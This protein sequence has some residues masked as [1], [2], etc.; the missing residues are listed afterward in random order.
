MGDIIGANLI[1]KRNEFNKYKT[2]LHKAQEYYS[3][4]ILSKEKVMGWNINQFEGLSKEV[5][6]LG[7]I[8]D[9]LASGKT[10]FKYS[11]KDGESNEALQRDINS[12]FSQ[13]N[14][15]IKA[16]S[17]S[18]SIPEQLIE[19]IL[20]GDS[21]TVKNMI[22]TQR[23][24]YKGLINKNNSYL[25]QL[26]NK[27]LKVPSGGT[28]SFDPNNEN[29][30]VFLN[31]IGNE[32]GDTSNK[33]DIDTIEKFKEDIQQK[34]INLYKE[35]GKW[36]G[37][38]FDSSSDL[39]E[40]GALYKKERNN[41]TPKTSSDNTK[42]MAFGQN[43]LDIVR[44][45]PLDK[46]LQN[47]Y[48]ISE[49]EYKELMNQ[50]SSDQGSKEDFIRLAFNLDYPNNE[51]T[52]NNI[53]AKVAGIDSSKLQETIPNKDKSYFETF[54]NDPVL[55]K[56]LEM[57][58]KGFEGAKKQHYDAK[59]KRKTQSA[60]KY[61]AESL[62]KV[63]S[64]NNKSKY[65]KLSTFKDSFNKE[66]KKQYDNQVKSKNYPGTYLAWLRSQIESAGL[67]TPIGIGGA[68]NQ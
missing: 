13:I 45:Q 21:Q 14:A 64:K 54:F 22:S 66:M 68:W 41:N 19:P 52:T 47:K 40:L 16:L 8:N 25:K 11:L 57:N 49:T 50:Y 23:T 32:F 5:R 31:L 28:V 37:G 26:N 9:I 10:K 67:Y 53:L 17:I 34:Q 59:F 3:S 27:L 51:N 39:K 56:Q 38:E 55:T 35:Y 15:G 33:Y 65:K 58:K 18:K 7:E 62:W 2:A 61:L 1:A 30:S 29:E 63:M 42:G 44:S 12:R 48:N 4:G 60:E 46:Q 43:I 20:M 36:T 6:K 24:H